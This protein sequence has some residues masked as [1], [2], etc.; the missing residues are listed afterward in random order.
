MSPFENRRSLSLLLAPLALGALMPWATWLAAGRLDCWMMAVATLGV[1]MVYLG[2]V[3]RL[4]DLEL[5]LRRALGR[6]YQP[7]PPEVVLTVCLGLAASFVIPGLS[8]GALSEVIGSPRLEGVVRAYVPDEMASV[9]ARVSLSRWAFSP[10]T[11][12][13]FLSDGEARMTVS[14]DGEPVEFASAW[15]PE[16]QKI[17]VERLCM[18]VDRASGRLLADGDIEIGRVRQVGVELPNLADRFGVPWELHNLFA[19]LSIR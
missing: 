1:G 2:C 14:R 6:R 10:G 5:K 19:N 18:T 8:C 4:G 16:G 3:H 13:A 7:P 15:R 17:C 11:R 12:L 9:G